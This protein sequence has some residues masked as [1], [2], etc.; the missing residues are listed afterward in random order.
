MRTQDLETYR[1]RPDLDIWVVP[2]F[3]QDVLGF[4]PAEL[5]TRLEENY[6]VAGRGDQIEPG[7]VQWVDGANEAL[8][9]RGHELKRAKIWLQQGDPQTVGYVKYFYT[10]WQWDIIVATAD[11]AKCP[12]VSPIAD[13]YDQ[14]V[15][16]LGASR[17][18]HYIITRYADGQ[19]HI[20][21]HFDKP[22]SIQKGSLI[23]VV[24]TGEHGRPF[25][26][27]E[28]VFPAQGPNE[29][30]EDFKKRRA[31]EQEAKKP[32]F[33]EVLAPGTAVIMTLEANLLT[34]HGVPQVAEAGPSGSIVFRTITE[35]GV[36]PKCKKLRKQPSCAKSVIESAAS[37]SS[38]AFTTVNEH[39]LMEVCKNTPRPEIE[40]GAA[41]LVFAAEEL[42]R[43][44]PTI[45]EYWASILRGD[46]K[47]YRE[48]KRIRNAGGLA[49]YYAWGHG[50]LQ[51]EEDLEALSG[52]IFADVARLRESALEL[53]GRSRSAFE[54]L[55]RAYRTQWA[56]LV[57][58]MAGAALDY[59][60]A[61][62][63]HQ[64]VF[65]AEL[66]KF[67]GHGELSQRAVG[68]APP[69]PK[70]VLGIA[71]CLRP[72]FRAYRA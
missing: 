61:P 25:Q 45:V 71:I 33:D 41:A 32:F 49:S 64:L 38:Q 15:D 36:K 28:R 67:L 57:P 55:G 50:R 56:P 21:F 40:E 53:R 54:K 62:V 7:S 5:Q 31:K 30:D 47:S 63:V 16:G 18:N 52:R 70:S 12:E 8:N 35:V 22:K 60:G 39:L 68:L 23:T 6:P 14:W 27:R 10:G 65:A 29:A 26:L 19:H 42:G 11:V 34:Q 24:K 46:R 59:L 44:R 43:L 1:V 13:R 20:G 17:A 72:A 66:L 37:L 48:C 9:Y 51:T 3:A 2:C 58:H 4:D 69:A